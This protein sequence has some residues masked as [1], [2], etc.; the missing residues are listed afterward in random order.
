MKEKFDIKYK[1]DIIAGKLNVVTKNN[2]PVRIICWNYHGVEAMPIL[3]L[4]KDEK[5]Y[6]RPVCFNKD[7]LY[8]D[9]GR[10]DLF[11][12]DSEEKSM[13]FSSILRLIEMIEP[14]SRSEWYC[15]K[16]AEALD[17]EGYKV[18]AKLVREHV[19][20]MKGE[21][22]SM[23]V[24]DKSSMYE[25]LDKMLE[26]ALSKETA[27]SWKE[28]LGE[29]LTEFEVALEK[30]YNRHLHIISDTNKDVKE[31]LVSG[32]KIL[33][34]IA[35]KNYLPA[36]QWRGDNLKEVLEFTGKDKRFDEWF[37]DFEDYQDYVASHGNIFKIFI[38]GTN[39]HYECKVGYW[40]IKINGVNYP[41]CNDTRR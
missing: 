28:F 13:K 3:G 17:R 38:E 25:K 5:G 39:D 35:R 41:I 26:D 18:D 40:I 20:M 21:K 30:F 36:I 22:V 11:V 8:G 31:S 4:V 24:Q 12:I 15:E 37:K 19:R 6:E 2:Q 14:S 32:A 27:E 1:D 33:L 34:S 7:G 29:E 10:I 16:L 23:A 9:G